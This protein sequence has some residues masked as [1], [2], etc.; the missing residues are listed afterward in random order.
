[1]NSSES[2]ELVI[3]Q[4]KAKLIENNI[5]K[6]VVATFAGNTD[7]TGL[8]EKVVALGGTYLFWGLYLFPFTS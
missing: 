1:V 7:S 3:V 2:E 4:K 6:N 5:F 8:I